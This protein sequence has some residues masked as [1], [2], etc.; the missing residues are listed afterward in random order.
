MGMYTDS[1][2]VGDVSVDRLLDLLADRRRRAVLRNLADEPD[3][4]MTVRE[5]RRSL[6]RDS[7]LSERQ[8]RQELHHRHLPA[9]S[10]AGLVTVDDDVVRYRAD[11]RAER[12][13]ETIDAIT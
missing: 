13:L 9:L 7:G 8:L 3:E 6:H 5:L 10:D 4:S 12:L 1:A 11:H 2:R